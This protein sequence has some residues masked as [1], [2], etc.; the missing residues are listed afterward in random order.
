MIR[1]VLA[2]AVA[3]ALLGLAMPAAEDAGRTHSDARVAAELDRIERAA[4][5]LRARSG[6]AA[7]GQTARRTLTVTLPART[8]AHPGLETLSVP[9]PD[10]NRRAVWRVDGGTTQRRR[11]PPWLVGPPGGFTVRE[12]GPQRIVLRLRGDR[13]VVRR[14]FMSEAGGNAGHGT[15]RRLAER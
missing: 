14:N 6:T 15:A 12:G 13:V 8:W 1:V 5:T 9:G 2:V 11:L 10:G 4:R 7:H 3:A